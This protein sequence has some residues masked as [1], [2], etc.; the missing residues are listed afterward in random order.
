MLNAMRCVCGQRRRADQLYRRPQ[1][2]SEQLGAL[3]ARWC[4]DPGAG[5]ARS[6]SAACRSS[7]LFV[8]VAVGALAGVVASI[9]HLD[10]PTERPPRSTE[11]KSPGYRGWRLIS[12]AH[13]E[14]NLNDLRA[15]LG[16]DV[17]KGLQGREASVSGWHNHCPTCL[18][19][20]PVGRKQQSLWPSPIFRGRASCCR[21]RPC[22][23]STKAAL[24]LPK[25][26]VDKALTSSFSNAHRRDRVAR[27]ERHRYPAQ[28]ARWRSA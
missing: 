3:Q 16:N 15:I 12:A 18:K 10:G 19:L 24:D 9:P 20:R 5:G 11:P 17:A 1:L 14:G 22:C 28:A 23:R 6:A 25:R 7:H 8:L 2:V 4:G 27:R 26:I 21:P 13:E